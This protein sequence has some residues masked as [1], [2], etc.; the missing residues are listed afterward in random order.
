MKFRINGKDY[1]A[2]PPEYRITGPF[3]ERVPNDPEEFKKWEKRTLATIDAMERVWNKNIAPAL[4]RM[5]HD[6]HNKTYFKDE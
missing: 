3:G 6:H 1:V 5:A 4:D 2:T